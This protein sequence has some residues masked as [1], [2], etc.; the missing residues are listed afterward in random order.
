[1]LN[2]TNTKLGGSENLFE[3]SQ[4]LKSYLCGKVIKGNFL[5]AA[6]LLLLALFCLPIRLLECCFVHMFAGIRV[7]QK[8]PVDIEQAYRPEKLMKLAS[9][10]RKVPVF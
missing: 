5:T 7:C 6:L 4:N 9:H 10:A 8:H 3:G 2:Y 1:M